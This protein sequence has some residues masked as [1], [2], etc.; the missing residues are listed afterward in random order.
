M[1][2]MN[3]PRGLIRYTTE[4]LLAG[5]V[6]RILRPRTAIYATI[7]GALLAA[8]AWGVSHRAP[9]IV[10]VLHDRNALYREMADGGI[11]NGYTIKLVNKTDQ[12]Q[13]LQIALDGDEAA[14]RIVGKTHVTVLPGQVGNVP[15]T[16]HANRAAT[17]GRHRV[18]LLV[19]NDDDSI[20]VQHKTEFFAPEEK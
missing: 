3:Y 16:L 12:A 19:R 20:H 9:L 2:K 18:G 4:S 1:D 11:E 7:L 10:D 14:L 15:L 13:Q 8:F 6:R 5:R 17:K